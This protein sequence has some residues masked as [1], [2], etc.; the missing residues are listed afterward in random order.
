MS[1][2]LKRI[3]KLARDFFGPDAIDD[4]KLDQ[5][6]SDAYTAGYQQ[7]EQDEYKEWKKLQN[8]V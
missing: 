8:R 2:E 1:K 5:F 7:G 6:L 4:E 3:Q